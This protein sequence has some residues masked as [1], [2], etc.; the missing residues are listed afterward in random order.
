MY[1]Y[2]A[3][4]VAA[5]IRHREDIY[6]HRSNA[7]TAL[8]IMVAVMVLAGGCVSPEELARRQAEAFVQTQQAAIAQTAESLRL[9]AEAALK[10]A[11]PT[12]SLLTGQIG[13]EVYERLHGVVKHLTT[14]GKNLKWMSQ[15]YWRAESVAASA[16]TAQGNSSRMRMRRSSRTRAATSSHRSDQHLAH[17]SETRRSS[18]LPRRR[19]GLRSHPSPATAG[20]G[21]STRRGA[22]RHAQG[23]TA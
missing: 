23:N 9:T 12:R 19:A 6:P 16:S 7:G 5:A 17:W 1:S 18:R 13:V 4:P 8:L 3:A 21:G 20:Y 10:E 11:I 22:G 14:L 15:A 2:S